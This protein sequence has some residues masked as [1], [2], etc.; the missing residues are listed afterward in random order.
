MTKTGNQGSACHTLARKSSRRRPI[1]FV[2]AKNCTNSCL[3]LSVGKHHDHHKAAVAACS[4]TNE[5]YATTFSSPTQKI[6][7]ARGK[8]Q[9]AAKPSMTLF[10]F[11]S[12]TRPANNEFE[13]PLPRP[14]SSCMAGLGKPPKDWTQGISQ[15][16]D[17]IA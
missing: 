12:K 1:A 3:G 15:T 11:V 17:G 10:L 6:N 4:L 16:R 9:R 13:M 7:P 2:P 14:R 8:L 5:S